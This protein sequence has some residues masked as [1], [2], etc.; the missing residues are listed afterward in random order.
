MLG[1][2]HMVKIIQHFKG[3]YIRDKGF[4]DTLIGA[5]TLG[6]NIVERLFD[7]AHY[8]RSLRDLQITSEAIKPL[9]WES[10]VVCYRATWRTFKP[11]FEK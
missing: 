10:L 6:A 8:I 11:R 1:A 5:K 9:Q 4:E 3:K 7:G 2:F